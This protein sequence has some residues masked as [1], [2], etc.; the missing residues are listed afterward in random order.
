MD[1]RKLSRTRT[2]RQRSILLGMAVSLI[3]MSGCDN[4]RGAATQQQDARTEVPARAA[5]PARFQQPATV[6]P[7]ISY[8]A[9]SLYQ[10]ADELSHSDIR[11]AMELLEA[12]LAN[13]P[14]DPR[15]A[16]YYLLVGRLK[17]EFENCQLDQTNSSLEDP[18]KQCN[19]FTEYAN[20]RPTEYFYNEVGGDYL[21]RGVHFQELE[22]RFP[23]S[24]LAV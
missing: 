4:Q 18:K 5:P 19:G 14:D 3:A 11:K 2:E 9:D 13:A 8:E 21:Y 10:R 17:K 23:S 1:V 20:A 24:A 16:P 7:P 15:S 12:A 6:Q 22:K